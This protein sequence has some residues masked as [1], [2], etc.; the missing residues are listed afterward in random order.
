MT[1]PVKRFD[2]LGYDGLSALMREDKHGD[3]VRA[4]DYDAL[5]SRLDAAR[6]RWLRDGSRLVGDFIDS[7][8]SNICVCTADG[9][10]VL[11]F[12]QMD[13]VIDAAMERTS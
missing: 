4:E 13:S 5:Q 2:P 7:H 6:Y 10:D 12:E 8:E 11:W 3:W 1:E 9:E